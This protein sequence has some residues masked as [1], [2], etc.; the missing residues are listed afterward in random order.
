AF[1]ASEQ[2]L[3]ISIAV[4]PDTS[5]S[6]ISAADYMAYAAC[7][8]VTR[9]S[10]AHAEHGHE[11]L[12]VPLVEDERV[13]SLRFLIVELGPST[14]FSTA[15]AYERLE[16]LAALYRALSQG[17]QTTSP[18]HDRL[19]DLQMISDLCQREPRA[20]RNQKF[21]DAVARSRQLKQLAIARLR[22]GN[23]HDLVF[24]GVGKPS[25]TSASA[26]DLARAI[27]NAMTS[28]APTEN[29]A[30]VATSTHQHGAWVIVLA[31]LDGTPSHAFASRVAIDDRASVEAMAKIAETFSRFLAI[32]MG[33]PTLGE[34]FASVRTAMTDWRVAGSAT[35]I[36]ALFAAVPFPDRVEAPMRL[37]SKQQRIVTAPFDGVLDR[38]HMKVDD[39]VEAGKTILASLSTH[40]IALRIS[41]YQ[42]QL[43]SA[44][45][46]LSDAR[47]AHDP[48][49]LRKAQLKV[50]IAK[51]ELKL[52]EYRKSLADIRPQIDGVVA[53]S[54]VQMRAGTMV[55]RGQKLFEI[56]STG[57]VRIEI[58]VP[59]DKILKLEH[60]QK[61]SFALAAT[62]GLQHQFVIAH[63]YPSAEVVAGRTV[64]RVEGQLVENETPG[65]R[66]GMEGLAR[67]DNGSAPLGWLMIRDIVSAVRGY[68]WV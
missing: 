42:A 31:W 13:A 23:V 46:E 64:F 36:V 34:R 7:K 22:G 25:A 53:V 49:R 63:I 47:A 39:R 28:D 48:A 41:K 21:V 27:Q 54:E 40:D 14:P 9:C 24:S 60:G 45:A 55:S 38:V 10:L 20:R 1:G 67:V 32:D 2:P 30:A 65:M 68:F 15:L 52:L 37:L 8:S 61:G 12:V 4:S 19:G 33:P 51:S 58:L 26:A 56:A 59:D 35:A 3:P 29:E 62:P 43:S 66:A 6:P 16:L 57:D 44:N 50:K 11:R 18:T 5:P 17:G